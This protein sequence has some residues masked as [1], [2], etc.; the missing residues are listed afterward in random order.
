MRYTTNLKSCLVF[1]AFYV[2]TYAFEGMDTLH[3]D[4]DN[5]ILLR[6]HLH[7]TIFPRKYKYG[8][9]K[10]KNKIKYRAMKEKE[11]FFIYFVF[12]VAS[13]IMHCEKEICS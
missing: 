5:N 7:L 13:Y 6:I 12:Y 9:R 3:D 1:F 8:H 11:I 4:K 10:T 2:C